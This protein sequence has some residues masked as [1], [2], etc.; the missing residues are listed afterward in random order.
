M[1]ILGSSVN[2]LQAIARCFSNCPSLAEL[3][4]RLNGTSSFVIIDCCGAY[5]YVWCIGY[6]SFLSRFTVIIK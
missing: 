3:Y 4:N 6:L 2:S 5:P 1:S